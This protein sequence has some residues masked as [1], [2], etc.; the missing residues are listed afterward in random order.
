MIRATFN[1]IPFADFWGVLHPGRSVFSRT[2]YRVHKLRC[3]PNERRFPKLDAVSFFVLLCALCVFAVDYKISC[4]FPI[5]HLS[6]RIQLSISSA[7][8][9]CRKD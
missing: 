9:E 1:T 4:Y 5:S 8:S 3:Q 7:A 2:N 6:L